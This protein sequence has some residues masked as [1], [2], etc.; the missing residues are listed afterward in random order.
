MKVMENYNL[1]IYVRPQYLNWTLDGVQAV[2]DRFQV[3]IDSIKIN[4]ANRKN[5]FN[6]LAYK[7]VVYFTCNN[8]KIFPYILKRL[9]KEVGILE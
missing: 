5:P 9:D 6:R 7:V 2:M 4:K 3:N 8:S 1:T